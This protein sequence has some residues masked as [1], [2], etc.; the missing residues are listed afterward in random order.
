MH[1]IDKEVQNLMRLPYEDIEEII[2]ALK[3]QDDKEY[4]ATLLSLMNNYGP[5]RVV[6]LHSLLEEW[7]PRMKEYVRN[8]RFRRASTFF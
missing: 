7:R 3:G 5:E 6:A 8:E 1:P 2:S 4:L